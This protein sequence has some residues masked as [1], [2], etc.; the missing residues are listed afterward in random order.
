MLEIIISVLLDSQF[1]KNNHFF[2][3]L[4]YDYLVTQNTTL[5]LHLHFC[6]ELIQN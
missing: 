6:F 2:I 5:W 1:W 4:P 3:E